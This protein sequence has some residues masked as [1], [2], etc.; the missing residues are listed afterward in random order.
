MDEE[1]MNEPMDAPMDD[2]A[3][4]TISCPLC[5]CATDYIQSYHFLLEEQHENGVG[6]GKLIRRHYTSILRFT[7]EQRSQ[8]VTAH[9][10]C[11]KI[12]RRVFKKDH[13]DQTW[14]NRFKDHLFFLRDF[15]EVPPFRNEPYTLDPDILRF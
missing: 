6:T 4:P 7:E 10:Y 15:L 13:F 8:E 9:D 12:A 1:H 14:I 5:R 11:W 3:E 2:A